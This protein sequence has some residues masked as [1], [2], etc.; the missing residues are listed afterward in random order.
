MNKLYLSKIFFLTLILFVSK[1]FFSFYFSFEENFVTK[2]FFDLKDWQYFTLIYNFANFDFN[3]S[4]DPSLS[5][6]KYIPIPISSVI[7]HS[8]FL[9]IFNLYGFLV[10]E[11]III[12][13]FFCIFFNFFKEL[14]VKNFESL[15]F[16]LFIFCV[17]SLI[18]ILNLNNFTYVAALHEFFNLRIPRPLVSQIY[19]FL[20]FLLLIF[21][22]KN[23]KFKIWEFIFLGY[24]FSSMWG[25][26]FYN[27][28]LAS[29]S[30]T[31]YY[32]YITKISNL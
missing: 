19:L 14:R 1:W 6:L 12:F 16:V 22:N 15:I 32:F 3:P 17:P 5:N 20:F 4:Y 29:I 7:F 13:L 27:L 9:K 10:A 25:S 30:F 2:A 21:K 31:I 24:L 8:I 26:F 11:F 28:A 18:D 23:E